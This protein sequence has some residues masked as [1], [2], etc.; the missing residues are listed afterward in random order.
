MAYISILFI[1]ITF[2]FIFDFGKI[3]KGKS[4]AFFSTLIILILFS[5]L[6]Y[7]VGFDT[8][9]YMKVFENSIPTFSSFDFSYILINRHEPLF[10]LLEIVAKSIYPQFVTVQL[11]LSIILNLSVFYFIKRNTEYVFT[12]IL[13]YFLVIYISFNFETIRQAT[14][15]AIFL[16][17]IQ[18]IQQKNWSKYY[19]LSTVAVLFHV[20]AIILFIIP[21]LPKIFKYKYLIFYLLGAILVSY[22][23]SNHF[24]SII[25]LVAVTDQL[26][27]KASNYANNESY[28]GQRLNIAGVITHTIINVLIPSYFLYLNKRKSPLE[29]FQFDYLIIFYIIISILMIKIQLFYRLLDYFFPFL[30]ILQAKTF[31]NFVFNRKRF[32]LTRAASQTFIVIFVVFKIYGQ[33]FGTRY[34]VKNYHR[35]LPYSSVLTKNEDPIRE[36]MYWKDF[37]TN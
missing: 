24:A 12:S 14:S 29:I 27:T 6:R 17:A 20:S 37:T 15:V 3:K 32:S 33:F 2:T 4:F 19:M 13:F 26:A 11:I 9:R 35:Y 8:I 10:L 23:I 28:S 31:G 7:R 16:F 34:G 36:S 21:A 25:N 18:Y 5:G 22:I 30:I 1:L